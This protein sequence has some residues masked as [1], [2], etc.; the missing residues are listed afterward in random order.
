M[1]VIKDLTEKVED[2]H[3]SHLGELKQMEHSSNDPTPFYPKITSAPTASTTTT[4][5]LREKGILDYLA[6]FLTSFPR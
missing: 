2:Q 4:M 3:L 5:G 1:K 6:I